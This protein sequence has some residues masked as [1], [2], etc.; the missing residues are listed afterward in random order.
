[1][2]SA[3]GRACDLPR[4]NDPPH[5]EEAPQ[6][7]SRSTRGSRGRNATFPRASRRSLR[8]LLSMRE[9]RRLHEGASARPRD[10]A[11][12]SPS[13]SC[14]SEAAGGDVDDDYSFEE[15]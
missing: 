13:S 9:S 4:A 10:I 3:A 6:A 15:N 7:P 2:R 14:G 12:L 8:G 11:I 5:A 1:V